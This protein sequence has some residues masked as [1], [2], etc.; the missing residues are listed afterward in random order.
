M[1]PKE[2]KINK[3]YG[4][5]FG[6]E[7]DT[8]SS[9]YARV[10]SILG[11]LVK[12][13]TYIDAIDL[14]GR[15]PIIGPTTFSLSYNVFEVTQYIVD[16]YEKKERKFYSNNGIDLPSFLQ[17]C[18]EEEEYVSD[19]KVGDRVEYL[20]EVGGYATCYKS[21]DILSIGGVYDDKYDVEDVIS[22]VIQG[23]KKEQVKAITKKETTKKIN[24]NIKP[25][26]PKKG[27]FLAVAHTNRGAKLLLKVVSIEDNSKDSIWV[28]CSYISSQREYQARSEIQIWKADNSASFVECTDSQ[29]EWVQG[30]IDAGRYMLAEDVPK[31]GKKAIAVGDRCTIVSEVS[32][33]LYG[34]SGDIV[35]VTKMDT[36]HVPYRIVTLNG[37]TFWVTSD[38][39]EY[40][41]TP[42]ERERTAP[43]EREWMKDDF[44]KITHRLY[45]H[46]YAIGST[47]QIIEDTSATAISNTPYRCKSI[48][49]PGTSGF[50]VGK[51]E[52]VLLESSI[53]HDDVLVNV[54]A[55]ERLL[56]TE[57]INGNN[58][59]TGEGW[60]VS[61]GIF[62]DDIPIGS[63]TYSYTTVPDGCFFRD[64]TDVY[65]EPEK[66]LKDEDEDFLPNR[67]PK[68]KKYVGKPIKINEDLI[69]P[70]DEI[71]DRRIK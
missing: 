52:A 5:A 10:T 40:Y 54:T 41:D 28:H 68:A 2:C 12:S 32:S 7:M 8:T 66:F 3:I 67:V 30:C 34:A 50:W 11:T 24:T 64:L 15:R 61:S 60:K 19:F 42:A 45:G 55:S 56:G 62:K 46:G 27:D 22:G 20:G 39:L 65:N 37:V 31:K 38:M 25:P 58:I 6:S 29:K 70:L 26:L 17:E 43:S 36:S 4:F 57:T 16:T 33:A 69:E 51:N 47:V 53:I 35:S 71:I 13:D 23:I 18:V 63:G 14:E 1:K 48:T 9:Y 59:T 21:G 49:E 44:L